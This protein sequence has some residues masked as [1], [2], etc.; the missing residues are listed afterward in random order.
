MVSVLLT[1]TGAEI[2]LLS[3]VVLDS[4]VSIKASEICSVTLPVLNSVLDSLKHAIY[5][6]KNL[7]RVIF[8]ARVIWS[9]DSKLYSFEASS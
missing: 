9:L 6:P 7:V 8:L 5:C 3:A 4:L 2:C 1:N